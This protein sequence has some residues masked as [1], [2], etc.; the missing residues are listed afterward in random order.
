[1]PG[2]DTLCGARWTRAQ[3][4]GSWELDKCCNYRMPADITR[5]V[6]LPPGYFCP[7]H[8]W[9]RSGLRLLW[10]WA[11]DRERIQR[12]N[13]T[14]AFAHSKGIPEYFRK[15][16][17]RLILLSFQSLTLGHWGQHPVS[18]YFGSPGAAPRTPTPTKPSGEILG[19][20]CSE[21]LPSSSLGLQGAVILPW[22][23][24][25]STPRSRR[26]TTQTCWV[27]GGWCLG[28]ALPPPPA[29]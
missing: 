22:P 3:V 26:V 18:L 1:M 19:L 24:E 13:R 21:S 17:K 20:A 25:S 5:R 7:L 6:E 9:V 15:R 14:H 8:I 2:P 28:A 11:K 29:A 4:L 16:E 23:C 27:L 12:I 10:K